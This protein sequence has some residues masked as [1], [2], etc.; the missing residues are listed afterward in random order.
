MCPTYALAMTENRQHAN[1]HDWPARQ[2]LTN[3]IPGALK[4]H[5]IY[6]NVIKL[7]IQTSWT[8]TCIDN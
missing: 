3:I 7:N 2:A 1:A 6:Q 4:Q 5:T 8:T